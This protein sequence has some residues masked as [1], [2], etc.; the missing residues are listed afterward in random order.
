MTEASRYSRWWTCGGLVFLALSLMGCPSQQ[1]RRHKKRSIEEDGITNSH[2]PRR[3]QRRRSGSRL[4]FR[5]KKRVV[6]PPGF[7]LQQMAFVNP[8]PLM[9]NATTPNTTYI[10]YM[11]AFRKRMVKVLLQKS[12]K[13]PRKVMLALIMT[14]RKGKVT[15]RVLVEA[16]PAFSK[17][18]NKQL[19]QS[20]LSGLPAA[21]KIRYFEHYTLFPIFLHDAFGHHRRLLPKVFARALP[22]RFAARRRFARLSS[23]KQLKRLQFWARHQALPALGMIMS[24]V[25]KRFKGVRGWGNSLLA[26]PAVIDARK[27]TDNNP[28]Y[29]RAT[30]EMVKTNQIVPAT[31]ILLHLVKGEVD[32]ARRLLQVTRFFSRKGNVGHEMLAALRWRLGMFYK[33][34]TRKLKFGVQLHDRKDY[35][36][37]IAHYR[38]LLKQFPC[39]SHARYELYYSKAWKRG[40]GIKSKMFFDWHQ[41]SRHIF[42]CDPLFSTSVRAT[43]PV[44]AYHLLRRFQIRTLFKSRKR[45][46]WDL[47]EYGDIATELGEF[48]FAA[49]LY[50]WSYGFVPGRYHRGRDLRSFFLYNMEKLNNR[51]LHKAFSSRTRAQIR[52][53]PGFFRH[54]MLNNRLY[55]KMQKNKSKKKQ[56][57][58]SGV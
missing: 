28:T 38:A 50:W 30:V 44:Q 27:L 52:Q 53:I 33:K 16:E 32:I 54:K 15:V 56:K 57:K 49:H 11:V 12:G 45:L 14:P 43:T 40:K 13:Q 58:R 10:S 18:K 51:K 22:E 5:P 29:W 39:S 37:A 1:V 31:K 2:P 9:L 3:A 55:K 8:S 42:A 47:V 21:P 19:E 46:A 6:F 48:G 25:P 7:R 41:Q 20:L 36:G 26:L 34:F 4:S 23:R 17:T 24:R 35:T